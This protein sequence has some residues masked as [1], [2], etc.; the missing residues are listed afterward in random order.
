MI[1]NKFNYPEGL[2]LSGDIVFEDDVS[3]GRLNATDIITPEYIVG[4]LGESN[5]LTFGGI[6]HDDWPVGGVPV[7][8][9]IM[10]SGAQVDIPTGWRLC[11]GTNGTPNLLDKFVVGAAYGGSGSYPLSSTAGATS[12][13]LTTANIISHTHTVS[14]TSL[15]GA[16]TD[17]TFLI[18]G[19]P[20]GTG[21]SALEISSMDG[22]LTPNYE[23]LGSGA[24]THTLT[25]ANPTGANQA[26]SNLPS[27]YTLAYIMYTAGA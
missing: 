20:T 26:H 6:T 18:G 17:H 2:V 1:P 4:F 19:I 22:S 8:S 25:I 9:I 3:F 21:T 12:V 7:G 5:T 16:H 23:T 10:W 24:H 27:Y 13:T 15:D 14:G 11:D